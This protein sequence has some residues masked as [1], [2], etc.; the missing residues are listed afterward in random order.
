MNSRYNRRGTKPPNTAPTDNSSAARGYADF[1][2]M[3]WQGEGVLP[4]PPLSRKPLGTESYFSSHSV[5]PKIVMSGR[6]KYEHDIM[7]A[8]NH[9]MHKI[10]FRG[11]FTWSATK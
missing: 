6:G 11:I 3:A 1:L 4:I 8:A 9:I 7:V 5:T 2:E 10:P